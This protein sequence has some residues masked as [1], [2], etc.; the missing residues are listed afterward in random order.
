MKAVI[1]HERARRRQ[2]EDVSARN[3]GYDLTSLDT[4]SGEIHLIE[5]KGLSA[6][7]GAI[8]LTPNERRVAEDRRDCYWLYI[9]TNCLPAAAQAGGEEPVLQEPIFDPAKYAWNEVKKVQHYYLRVGAM[10]RPMQ[11]PQEPDTPHG[12]EG[13]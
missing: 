2:V 1:E 10:T 3:L 7:D 12:G 4:R 13:A 8:L 6:L 5:V 9:V 11:A